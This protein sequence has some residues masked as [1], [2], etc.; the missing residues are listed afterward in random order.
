ME[1]AGHG[2][3]MA[4]QEWWSLLRWLR[5]VSRTMRDRRMGMGRRLVWGSMAVAGG[6]VIVDTIAGVADG[7]VAAGNI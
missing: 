6:V 7:V 2:F 1:C 4:G 3:F 5:M